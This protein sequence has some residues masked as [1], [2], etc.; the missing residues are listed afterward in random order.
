MFRIATGVRDFHSR[1]PIRAGV[2]EEG[3]KGAAQTER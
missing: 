1:N 3:R 2:N